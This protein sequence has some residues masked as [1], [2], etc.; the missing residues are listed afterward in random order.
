MRKSILSVLVVAHA[1]VSPITASADSGL[2]SDREICRAAVKSYF[3]LD[4]NPPDTVDRG[5][6]FGFRSASGNVYTCRIVGTRVE[7]RWLSV[8]GE[9]MDSNSTRFRVLDEM[10]TIQTDMKEEIFRAK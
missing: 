8:S 1:V 3:F 4:I 9:A 10:L 7:F 6:F 5:D 2:W